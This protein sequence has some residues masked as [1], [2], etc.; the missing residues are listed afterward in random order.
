MRSGADRTH[1]SFMP[2]HLRKMRSTFLLAVLVSCSLQA[3]QVSVLFLGNS[4]TSANDLPYTVRTLALSLGDTVNTTMVAPGG[5]QL[6]DHASNPASLAGIASAPWDFVVMQDQS[7]LGALPLS[8]T[9][10]EAGAAALVQAIEANNECTYPVFYMTWGRQNGDADNCANFPFMCTYEGMQ[11]GLRDNYVT[12]AEENDGHVAPVGVAWKQVRGTHPLINLYD[13]DGSHPS[14]EG[15]YLAACVLYCTLFQQSCT[16]AP[17]NAWLQPDTAALLRAI[18]SATVLDSTN[19]WNLDVANGTDATISG[20]SSNGGYDITFYHPGQGM[21]WWVCSDGQSSTDAN[22]TFILPGPG[23][24]TFSHTY[25]DPCGN[26]DT[27]TW[28]TEVY[29]IGIT[30]GAGQEHY[31]VWSFEPGSVEVTGGKGNAVLNLFDMEGRSILERPL[32]QHAIRVPCATGVY[33]WT[34][35]EGPGRVAQGK[36]VVR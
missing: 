2:H 15:T 20:S 9:A 14:D 25:V 17:Y 11:Q 31:N 36:V 34:I 26:L 27:V 33:A 21:H 18:A 32:G 29:G 1:T 7:Q 23:T 5:Y 22:P 13:P 4:Y 24:Y 19:T 30:E 16:S 28:T 35:D 6:I 3:Q 12:V 10:M 8:V